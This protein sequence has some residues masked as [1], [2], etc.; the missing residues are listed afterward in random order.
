[1]KI[2]YLIDY[3]LHTHSGV[4]QKIKE[5]S[6]Q[7]TQK[8]HTVY[9]VSPKTMSVYDS[10]HNILF[11]EKP[12]NVKLGRVGTAINLLYNAYFTYKLFQKI[13]FDLIYMRYRLYMPFINKIFKSHKVIMEIN[14]DDTL[15]YKLHSKL[16]HIYNKLT[17]SLFLKNMNAFISVSY[18]LKKKFE[19]LNKPMVVIANGININ[20]YQVETQKSHTAP[21]LVFIGTPKQP[22]HGVDKIIMMANFFKMYQFYIIGFKGEDSGNIHYFGYLS[23]EESTKIINQCDI[24][25]G[26]LSLYKKSMNEASPLKTRQY[27]ACGL[28]LIYA[29]DDTDIDKE[30]PFILK[31]SN[32]ENN[33]IDSLDKIDNFIKSVYQNKSIKEN[34]K[35]FA[36]EKL[37]TSIKEDKRLFFFREI[38]ESDNG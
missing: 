10:D 25:I 37:D 31:I 7:W 26:T 35:R 4:I 19:F 18:E 17:R 2:A 12:L 38:I 1:M 22:W 15:E 28:P 13:E 9:F 16:T 11:Q 8:G 14:S 3:D 34:A 32:S 33:V 21:I 24:G 5:Q 29:Y 30:M 20:D 23:K 6:L 36:K 27:L